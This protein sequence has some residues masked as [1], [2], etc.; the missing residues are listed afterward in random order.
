MIPKVAVPLIRECAREGIPMVSEAIEDSSVDLRE[1]ARRL[2]ALS[3]L[4]DL[5]GWSS[6]EE[7]DADVDATD[8]AHTLTEVTPALLDTLT[9]NVRRA[10]LRP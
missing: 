5:I 9:S 4:F 10:S 2:S 7:A 3:D 6:G 8:H 1:C